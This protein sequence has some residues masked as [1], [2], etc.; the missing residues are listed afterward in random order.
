[1]KRVCRRLGL[2][3]PRGMTARTEA[4][5]AYLIENVDPGAY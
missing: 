1:M 5:Q 2:A 3:S 4:D